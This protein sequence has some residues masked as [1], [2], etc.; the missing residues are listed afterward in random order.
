[1]KIRKLSN[2]YAPTL[3]ILFIMIFASCASI[4]LIAPYDERIEKGTTELQKNTTTFF[5]KVE[6]QGGSDINDY[7][8]HIEFYDNSKVATK[9][10]L[11][12]AGATAQNKKTEKQ[13]LLVSCENNKS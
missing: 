2:L 13:M 11:I 5:V 9:S 12:R 4:Q 6:R 1:M 10:L 8:N 3:A 7:K